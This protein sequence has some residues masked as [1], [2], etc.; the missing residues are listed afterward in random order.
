MVVLLLVLLCVLLHSAVNVCSKHCVQP[1]CVCVLLCLFPVVCFLFLR[2]G[3]VLL[4]LLVL[5]GVLDGAS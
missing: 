2:A 5:R 1:S 3:M 4:V